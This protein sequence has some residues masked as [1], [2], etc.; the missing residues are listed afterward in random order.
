M[1]AS[2]RRPLVLAARGAVLLV[3]AVGS[4]GYSLAD[5]T[6]TISADG[7]TR[8]VHTFAGDVSSALR[9]AGVSIGTHDVV[10]PALRQALHDGSHIV[11]DR[12]R[13]LL[14]SVNG[15]A[16]TVWITRSD[17][18]AA[19][20]LD[21]TGA[22]V[23]ASRDRLVVR[24]PQ[25]VRLTVGGVASTVT[26][27]A[28]TV[29]DLLADQGV[30]LGPFDVVSTPLSAYPLTATAVRVTQITHTQW[31]QRT[32]VAMPTVRVADAKLGIGRTQLAHGGKAGID[33]RL[34]GI[35][36]EDGQV[37]LRKLLTET[38]V[39]AKAKVIRYGTR[40]ATVEA[41]AV[42]RSVAT[43]TAKS[44]ANASVSATVK[45]Q[46]KPKPV[47]HRAAPKRHTLNWAALARC[48]SGGDPHLVDGAYYGLY[49]FS[50]G[51]WRSVGGR[52]R[53]S[54]ASSAEQT[55]RAQLL[56]AQQGRSPWPACGHYL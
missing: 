11:V 36:R 3:M 23:S 6:V 45:A 43:V 5:K 7:Q 12:G 31:L 39:A 50:L 49:Q 54:D 34:W 46:A 42:R 35:V 2:T 38:T 21:L 20:G 26:T 9:R 37:V 13:P 16:R 48:E 14:L 19:L 56:Y 33:Y 28:A 55:H 41:V 40:S 22:Y 4:V 1:Q 15:S 53:P 30:A 47:V 32:P 29:A 18:A 24:T 52:G 44:T 17:A 51:T 8:T 25:Q 27:T 10:L